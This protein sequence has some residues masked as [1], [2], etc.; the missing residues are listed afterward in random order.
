MKTFRPVQ[1]KQRRGFTLIELLVVI[2]IIATLAALIL[3]AVQNAR[4][5]ARRAEC[6]NNMKQLCTAVMNFTSRSNGRLPSMY[7][8][9][10]TVGN[11]P[12]AAPIYRSWAVDLLP[13]LD[14]AAMQRELQTNGADASTTNDDFAISMKMFQCP[15]DSNNFQTPGGLSYVVNG[16]Y[17]LDDGAATTTS[18]WPAAT[19]LGAGGPW[20]QWAGTIDWN[21][22]SVINE[23]DTTIGHATGIFFRPSSSTLAVVPGSTALDSFTDPLSQLNSRRGISLD[24]ITAGDGQTNT[25]MFAENV[26][27]R[28][29]DKANAF[30]EIAFGAPCVPGVDVGGTGATG[31]L[32]LNTSFRDTLS[33][34]NAKP[35]DQII[36]TPGTLPRPSSNHLGTSIYGFADGA[37]RQFADQ[38]DWSV[39]VRLISPNGQRYGQTTVGLEDY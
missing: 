27:A 17:V 18:V 32:S 1:K 14:N 36:A 4:A 7:K 15:V 24:Y 9:W 38:I 19:T 37:A 33:L 11:A 2:S 13:D 8:Q 30:S 16:G 29:W 12:G 20:A 23:E 5:A 39:Y 26:Q 6:Q 22:D 25:I 21:G 3:P 34:N 35:G 31:P 28:N 10:G